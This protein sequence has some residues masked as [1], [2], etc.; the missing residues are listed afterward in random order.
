MPRRTLWISRD[1]LPTDARRDARDW[2]SSAAWLPCVARL[3]C[4]AAAGG[5][6]DDQDVEELTNTLSYGHETAATHPDRPVL[7]RF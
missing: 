2:Q 4:P 3:S 7:V 6:N 1:R 5:D